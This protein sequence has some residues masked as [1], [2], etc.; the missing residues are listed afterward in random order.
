MRKQR[1]STHSSTERE[2]RLQTPA[3]ASHVAGGQKTEAP[4]C[5]ETFPGISSEAFHRWWSEMD[6]SRRQGLGYRGAQS[7]GEMW[8]KSGTVRGKLRHERVSAKGLKLKGL[9]VCVF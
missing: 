3:Q 1:G 9:S 6:W 4:F 5:L 7:A 2:G 8:T